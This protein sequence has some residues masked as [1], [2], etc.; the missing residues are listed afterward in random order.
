MGYASEVPDWVPILRAAGKLQCRPWELIE[1]EVPK[2]VWV[3]WALALQHA[4]NLV[5][6]AENE[7]RSKEK[8]RKGGKAIGNR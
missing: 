4:D 5:Q 7:E 3:W 1:F 8:P 6:E 2:R